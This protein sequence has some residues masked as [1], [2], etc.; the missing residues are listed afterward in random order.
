MGR[1]STVSPFIMP[2]FARLPSWQLRQNRMTVLAS[3]A[4]VMVPL[5][6]QRDRIGGRAVA[7]EGH[8]LAVERGKILAPQSILA[9]LGVVDGLVVASRAAVRSVAHDATTAVAEVGAQ[10]ISRFAGVP[11]FWAIAMQPQQRPRAELTLLSS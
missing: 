9:G 11:T 7:A 8:G 1:V 3:W 10:N 4:L 6:R 5:R 2:T